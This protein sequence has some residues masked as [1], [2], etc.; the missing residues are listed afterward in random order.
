MATSTRIKAQNI[1]FKIGTTDYS[2]DA[3][4]VELTLNDEIGRAH[5]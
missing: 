5:V 1:L 2:C 4:M 3:N